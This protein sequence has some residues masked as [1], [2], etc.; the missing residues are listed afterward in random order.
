MKS[1]SCRGF[2]RGFALGSPMVERP[3]H[4]MKF[5]PPLQALFA[6]DLTQA[7]AWAML[8]WPFGPQE[9]PRFSG[10]P[11]G[12]ADGLKSQK[13]QLRLSPR[14]PP[15]RGIQCRWRTLSRACQRRD[16]NLRGIE[17]ATRRN[18]WPAIRLE[19]RTCHLRMSRPPIRVARI[20][21]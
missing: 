7:E 12:L 11:N 3:V 2:P 16:V 1:L 8:S 4:C 6:R 5:P 10:F 18:A 9:S 19:G 14:A 21:R 20:R 17:S 15:G 13:A